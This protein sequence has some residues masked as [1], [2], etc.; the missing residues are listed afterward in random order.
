MNACS[1]VYRAS[2]TRCFHCCSKLY[3]FNEHFFAIS[4]IDRTLSYAPETKIVL[5]IWSAFKILRENAG[6]TAHKLSKQAKE[7]CE[8]WNDKYSRKEVC[9]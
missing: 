9:K 5:D 6:F 1:C 3:P 8:K 7:L 4:A 2:L